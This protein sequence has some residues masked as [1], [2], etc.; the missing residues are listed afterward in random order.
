MISALIISI[1]VHTFALQAQAWTS[2]PSV[3][4]AKSKATTGLFLK[5]SPEICK[6]QALK[7]LSVAISGAGPCGLLFAHRLLKAGAKC[8]IYESRKDP[9]KSTSLRGR[10]YALGLGIRGR[11]AIKTVDESLW[12][13]V[14]KRGFESERFDLHLSPKVKFRLRD[15]NVLENG[16]KLDPSLLLYQSDLCSVLLDELES[17]YDSK[18]LTLRFKST[19]EKVNFDRQTVVCVPRGEDKIIED[20]PFDLVAGCDGVNSRIRESMESDLDGFEVEK[21]PLPGIFKVVRL[22][23]MPPLLDPTSIHLIASSGAFVEPT[24]DGQCCILFNAKEQN[25]TD[26]SSITTFD[27][28][29]KSATLGREIDLKLVIKDFEAKN[30]LL[31]DLNATDIILQ[32]LEQKPS[33]AFAVKC[34]IY[35]GAG[36][37][38]LLGDAAHATGGVTGQGCNSA[39]MDSV[40]LA[41]SLEKAFS[42]INDMSKPDK[43]ASALMQYSKS[44]V[45]EGLALYDLAFGAK[46]EISPL[47]NIKIKAGQLL[48]TFF[49]GKF[50]LGKPL[51]QT[52][53]TTTLTP[54]ST[55]R[56]D[57]AGRYPYKFPE[58]TEFEQKLDEIT[59]SMTQKIKEGNKSGVVESSVDP[60]T[61]IE[62]VDIK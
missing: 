51:L 56:R 62:L 55:I 21:E 38:A 50:G 27:S 12:G 6:P 35:H 37:V 43:I 53:A 14:K 49:G 26:T 42:T 47:M 54:F 3:R 17:R 13:L 23:I 36:F 19:I 2:I 40:A 31:K 48:D 25:D 7:G 11:T 39:L 60:S 5:Q 4:V 18:C 8:T 32:L 58:D 1:A 46:G 34:N 59:Q 45:P 30:P 44:Q 22:P 33:S 57:R 41:N 24:A 20:G 16:K 52:Q 9:R 28:L 15:E 29:V 61:Q 10:A